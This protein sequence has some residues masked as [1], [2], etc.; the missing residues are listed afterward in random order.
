MTP[1][2]DLTPQE[3][4]VARLAAAGETNARSPPD[5]FL[6]SQYRRVPPPQGVPKARR[7]LTPPAQP[8]AR[9][10][11]GAVATRRSSSLTTPTTRIDFAGRRWWV[12]RATEPVGPGGNCF[13]DSTEAVDV[14]TDGA[15]VLRVRHVGPRW[16]CAEIVGEDAT[17]FGTYEWTALSDV[18][19]LPG[20]I[21]CGM[22]TW[23]ED[24]AH[25]DRELDVEVSAWDQPTGV[26]GK[27]VVQPAIPEHVR[28][29]SVPSAAP[30]RCSFDWRR[31][32]VTFRATGPRPW[33]APGRSAPPAGAVHPRL[34]L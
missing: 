1:T 27:F 34:N 31:D 24:P 22:F 12:K 11:D 25:D 17:G 15:L 18:R 9:R 7:D 5:S 28:R 21:V 23:S 26:V 16:W 4:H 33:T 19:R 3:A 20:D 32:G 10:V 30:W 2:T 29:F 14:G 13:D 6:S 8:C